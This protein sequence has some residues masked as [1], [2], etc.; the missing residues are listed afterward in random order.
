MSD[1]PDPSIF[2]MIGKSGLFLGRSGTGKTTIASELFGITKT[3]QSDYTGDCVIDDHA[4][5][6]GDCRDFKNVHVRRLLIG[7]ELA[8][9]L[10]CLEQR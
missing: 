1:L 4:G 2:R 6:R 3:K 10:R 9:T 7:S 8:Q 5:R